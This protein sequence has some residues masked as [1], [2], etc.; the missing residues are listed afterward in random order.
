VQSAALRDW[1]ATP[2]ARRTA[3]WVGILAAI[4][5]CSSSTGGSATT[6][7]GSDPTEC[8]GQPAPAP[9]F[10]G[11][12]GGCASHLVWQ[13]E[14]A[15]FDDGS[16]RGA[17]RVQGLGGYDIEHRSTTADWF[18]RLYLPS[19]APGTY[20]SQ[21]R[22]VDPP[23]PL[24]DVELDFDE[25]Y[26]ADLAQYG[27]KASIEV[28]G[29]D[30]RAVWGRFTGTLCWQQDFCHDIAGTFSAAIDSVPSEST[31]VPFTPC[32]SGVAP[33]QGYPPI[34][35]NCISDVTLSELQDGGRCLI[36]PGITND[37]GMVARAG[38]GYD[39]VAWDSVADPVP[40]LE[41]QLA[42]LQPGVYDVRSGAASVVRHID[43]V[44]LPDTWSASSASGSGTVEIAGSTA[45][46]AWG[47]FDVQACDADGYCRGLQGRFSAER[48]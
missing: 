31:D 27:A 1:R 37:Y 32:G 45:T 2:R 18:P 42:S 30:N 35:N 5:G 29:N 3:T 23:D 36:M 22:C 19:L 13:W 9:G 25:L 12:G 40:R 21:S 4:T 33:A 10:P 46:A 48:K 26:T 28:A 39:L 16:D 15:T 14:G 34:G 17:R 8:Q 11:I 24:A 47:R 44:Y 38:G 20:S 43:D 7:G 6:D 41:I